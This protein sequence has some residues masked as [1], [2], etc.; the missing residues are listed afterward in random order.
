MKIDVCLCD[1]WLK[2]G[3]SNQIEDIQS[4]GLFL[5]VRMELFDAHPVNHGPDLQC[6]LLSGAAVSWRIPFPTPDALHDR[7]SYD[8]TATYRPGHWLSSGAPDTPGQLFPGKYA[9]FSSKF[10]R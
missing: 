10:I 8:F 3:S 1:R 6:M 7:G 5:S 4:I 9:N 2:L